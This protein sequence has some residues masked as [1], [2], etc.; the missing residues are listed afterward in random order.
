LNVKNMKR[1]RL[2]KKNDCYI[3]VYHDD[4][5]KRLKKLKDNSIDSCVTDPPYALVSIR[6]R[7]SQT[8][9]ADVDKNFSKTIPG[10]GTNP[11]K[12]VARGF[13]GKTWDNGDT[14]FSVEFWIEVLRVLKPGSHVVAFGGTRTYHKLASAIDNAGF[15]I[16]DQLAWTH[17]QGFPKS[18]N[19]SKAFDKAAGAKRKVVGKRKHPTLKDTSKLDEKANAAHGNN[20]WKRE[21]DIT[22]S[23]TKLAKQ[24]EGW[25]TSIK[26]SWEPICLA[27]KPLSEK[28]IIANIKRWA[29]G[30]INV[31]ACRITMSEADKKAIK[32]MTGF[33]KEGY[34]R[35]KNKKTFMQGTPI[36]IQVVFKKGRWPA[37]LIHDGSQE[38]KE[39]FPNSS[40]TGLRKNTNRIQTELGN[41]SFTRG[42]QAPEYTDKGSVARFFYCAKAS[43]LDK[44]DSEHPTV[45]PIKLMRW[46]VR[47]VTPPGGIV[48]DCFA[49]T[50]TTG[51]AAMFEGFD[52][53]LI[54]KE[55]EY[56]DD[57]I[58][59]FDS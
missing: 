43:K 36:A 21:W 44:I 55:D 22:E 31:D 57:I 48:L 58:Y 1:Y 35:K 3:N 2:L 18:Q 23:S 54:E 39:L 11:F 49:G 32:N 14:A 34:I 5:L 25:G 30:A 13:L 52:S 26:P 16:R 38:V 4:C 53:I 7:L 17:G 10:Q 28:T 20:A 46:L 40:I 37:N 47:L 19:I 51:Y 9:K 59:R 29:V 12:A 24:W 8:N 15:E 41:T 45:K 42:K 6:K 50:G 56:I 27:R 33:G